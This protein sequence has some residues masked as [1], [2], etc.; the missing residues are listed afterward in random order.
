MSVSKREK[1]I[2]DRI[3]DSSSPV[4]G[5]TLAAEFGVSRQIIVK[6]IASL[7]TQ[8]HDIIATTKG[9]ILNKP[10][11]QER[12]FKAVHHDDEI[13]VKAENKE[14]L[15]RVFDALDSAGL[16]IHESNTSL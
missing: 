8:G 1:A 11:M 10:R 9:Y 2:L 13:T 12:V 6:D 5:S 16:I 3:S 14:T 15:D 7:K 4:S